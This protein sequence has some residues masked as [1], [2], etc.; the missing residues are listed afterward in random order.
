MRCEIACW[1]WRTGAA[2]AAEP[3]SACLLSQHGEELTAGH[4]LHEDVEAVLIFV[5]RSE[6]RDERVRATLEQLDLMTEQVR[7]RSH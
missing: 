4:V 7:D 3:A 6:A 2:A 1:P 5:R